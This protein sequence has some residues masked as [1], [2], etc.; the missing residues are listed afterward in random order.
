MQRDGSRPRGLRSGGGVLCIST[1][2]FMTGLILLGIYEGYRAHAVK[3]ST[4]EDDASRLA[5]KAGLYQTYA[6]LTW[7][8]AHLISWAGKTNVWIACSCIDLPKDPRLL[9]LPIH[10]QQYLQ[11][12][13][14]RWRLECAEGA[15]DRLLCLQCSAN[16]SR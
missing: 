10:C 8:I 5:C 14:I 2:Q 4:A 7:R 11:H 16:G 3:D 15:C 13:W 6:E 9:V 1:L 12:F